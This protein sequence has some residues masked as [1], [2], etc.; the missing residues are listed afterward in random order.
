MT[1]ILALDLAKRQTGSATGAGGDIPLTA[2]VSF[3][4][5]SRGA[6]GTAYIRWLRDRLLSKPD[7]VAYEAPIMSA[8]AKGSTNTLMLLIGLA[9]ITEAI[10]DMKNVPVVSVPA[11]TWRKAFLGVGYPDDPK[12]WAVAMCRSLGWKVQTEDEAEACGVLAWAHLYHGDASAMRDQ[13]SRATMKR[14]AR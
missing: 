1:R 7:L 8:K 10:C 5:P 3:N 2:S 13:L 6:V 11:P 9:F 14:M 4:V 12:A